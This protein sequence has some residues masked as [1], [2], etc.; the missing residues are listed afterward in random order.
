MVDIR[1]KRKT[2]RFI[3]LS[4]LREHAQQLDGFALIR[5]GNRLSV[6]PV[7]KQHWDFILALEQSK[8]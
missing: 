4:E 3:S 8:T 2:R 1:F 7:S 5:R 6:L